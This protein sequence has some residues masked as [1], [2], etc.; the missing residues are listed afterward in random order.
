MHLSDSLHRFKRLLR[1]VGLVTMALLAITGAYWLVFTV[2][3]Q[4]PPIFNLCL[5]TAVISLLI[6][7][8]VS[9]QQRV[10]PRSVAMWHFP[11]FPYLR[12]LSP[13]IKKR[14]SASCIIP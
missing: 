12:I 6:G 10:L 14:S 8:I 3:L 13:L 1:Q 4:S 7:P 11:G 9:I 2:W 5:V